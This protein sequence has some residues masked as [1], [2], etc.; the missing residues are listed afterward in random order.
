[1]VLPDMTDKNG[2]TGSSDRRRQGRA[3]IYL[4]DRDNMGKWLRA[5]DKQPPIR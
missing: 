1:M 5:N 3:Y 2:L 4:V